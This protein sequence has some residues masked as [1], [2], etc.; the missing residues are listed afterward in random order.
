MLWISSNHIAT[1]FINIITAYVF[2]RST[3]N[4]LRLF[5]RHSNL[6]LCVLAIEFNRTAKL[7]IRQ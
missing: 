3:L 7:L 1:I 6:V 4:L 2:K 5:K